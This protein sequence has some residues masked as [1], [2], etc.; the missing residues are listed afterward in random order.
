MQ[1]DPNPWP[2][3]P[4]PA[5][6]LL[7]CCGLVTLDV[8]Q[9]VERLPGPDEKVVASS[10][11]VAFGGPAANA[12]ATAVALGVRARLV[13]ALGSGPTADLVRAGLTAAGVQVV[14]LLAG[15]PGAPAVSSVLVTAGT[16]QRAVVSTNGTA[17]R[18]LRAEA[19]VVVGAALDGAGALLVDGHHLGAAQVLARVARRRGVPVLLDGGSWKAGLQD[20]LPWVDHAVLSA[21]FRL[22]AEWASAGGATLTR[23][24]AQLAAVAARGP[25]TVARSSGSGPVRMLVQGAVSGSWRALVPEVV[26]P[27]DVVDTLGAGDVLHGATG[28]G[29][30]R[31]LDLPAALAEGVRRATVSVRHEGALGWVREARGPL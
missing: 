25:R 17:V 30:A 28:A 26:A 15:E 11:D 24:D 20:L 10:V 7:M 14:D 21:D 19:E 16:G 6:P 18:D 8:R 22:P 31:G 23:D 3:P 29:L 12:A 9:V 1:P 13:T 5:S 27:Q 4:G 2:V